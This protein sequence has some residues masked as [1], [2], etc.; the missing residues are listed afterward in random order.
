[1]AVA[2]KSSMF[3]FFSAS[4]AAFRGL[5]FPPAVNCPR[6]REEDETKIVVKFVNIFLSLSKLL[7]GAKMCHYGPN[8]SAIS[9]AAKKNA[10][11]FKKITF[12]GPAFN[13]VVKIS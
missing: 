13:Q 7:V 12:F 11:N 1:M 8:F 4:F 2:A 6:D 3:H 10:E 5:I 9:S